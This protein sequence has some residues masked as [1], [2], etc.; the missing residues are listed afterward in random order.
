MNGLVELSLFCHPEYT[1]VGVGRKLLGTLLDVLARP[2]KHA[3]LLD[4]THREACGT[5]V[6]EVLAVMAVDPKGKNGRLA[7]RDFYQRNGFELVCLP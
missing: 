1:G 4:Q 7:L 6:K 3:D 5:K 2:E